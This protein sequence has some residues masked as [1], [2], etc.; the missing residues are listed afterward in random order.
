MALRN[1]LYFPDPRLRIKAKPILEITDE[2]RQLAD[3]LLETMYEHNGV[4]LAATQIDVHKRIIAIDVSD[5]R[6]QPYIFINPEILEQHDKEMMQ[7]GCLSF[8]N[9]FDA[10]ERNKTVKI[11]ALNIQGKSIEMEANALLAHCIQHEIEHLDGI[12]FSDHLSRLKQQ[13]IL[14]KMQKLARRAL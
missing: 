8:P 14:K 5:S 4:G 6:D 7:E 1:L 9:V 2:I 10:V 11:K 13:L 12:V 3:D